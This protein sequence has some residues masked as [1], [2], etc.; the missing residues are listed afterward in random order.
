MR[1][2]WY[3]VVESVEGYVWLAKAMGGNPM[4]VK[5]TPEQLA[6]KWG[7]RLKGAIEDMRRGIEAVTEAPGAKAAAKAD[8]WQ[9][10]ISSQDTKTKWARRIGA[11]TVDEWKRTMTEKGLPRV[12]AGVDN[13]QNKMQRFATQLIDHQNRGLVQIERMPDL[14]L[15][16]SINRMAAWTRHMAKFQPE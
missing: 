13:A 5:V 1:E 14:T 10:A 6:A 3:N 15:E 7:T 11:V 8:K 4:P 16:D 9:A 2:M 12:A